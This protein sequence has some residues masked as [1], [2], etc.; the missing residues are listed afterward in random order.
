KRW[1]ITY[2]PW[3]FYNGGIDP[4]EFQVVIVETG[5]TTINLT[6]EFHYRYVDGDSWRD[7]GAS[8]TVGLENGGVVEAVRYSFDQPVIFNEFAIGFVDQHYVDD[9]IGEFHLLTPEDGY[10][11][12]P[13][14]TIHFTWEAAEYSGHGSV[15][16]TLYLADNADFDDAVI[17][18]IGEDTEMHYIF[19]TDD[20]GSYWWKVL[21]DESDV[22]LT[23]WSE[24]VFTRVISQAEVFQTSWGVIIK[25]V[26]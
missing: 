8:A 7:H 18:E 4:I 17:F 15:N 20:V 12:S 9:Q 23:R 10:Q 25:A 26:F 21:A 22:G 11:G 24:E 6:V 19:G 13:G 1:Y 16:Y 14:E 2:S 5:L 3:Y